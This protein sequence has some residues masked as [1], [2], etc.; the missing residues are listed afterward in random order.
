MPRARESADTAALADERQPSAIRELWV[1]TKFPSRSKEPI[2]PAPSVG[3]LYLRERANT[4]GLLARFSA[5]F[6]RLCS[7]RSTAISVVFADTLFFVSDPH[8]PSGMHAKVTPPI[9]FCAK[10]LIS[11]FFITKIIDPPKNRSIPL[12]ECAAR[13]LINV[14]LRSLAEMGGVRQRCART[15]TLLFFPHHNFCLHGDEGSALFAGAI[16]ATLFSVRCILA[17]FPHVL[18]CM[19]TESRVRG[20]ENNFSAA[21]SFCQQLDPLDILLC[22]THFR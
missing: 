21:I 15:L 19:E 8:L 5:E 2:P 9:A 14:A 18:A 17:R 22:S 10:L 13:Y 6:V 1:P 3:I 7:C 16:A 4:A 12:L 11:A 20:A